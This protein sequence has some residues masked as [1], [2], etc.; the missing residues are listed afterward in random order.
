MVLT[1]RKPFIMVRG[2]KTMSFCGP[3]DL[4][5]LLFYSARFFVCIS[6]SSATQP[7]RFTH[8]F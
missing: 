5:L 4:V 2:V 3:V 7:F 1:P 8:M 6:V